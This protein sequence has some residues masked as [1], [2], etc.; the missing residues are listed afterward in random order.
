MTIIVAVRSCSTT[1]GKEFLIGHYRRVPRQTLFANDREAILSAGAPHVPFE[2]SSR[3]WARVEG[4][5]RVGVAPSHRPGHSRTYSASA[6][7]QR[8]YISVVSPLGK[9]PTRTTC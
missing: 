8:S 7:R 2:H 3:P 1:S 5:A 6:Q 9:S 4:R